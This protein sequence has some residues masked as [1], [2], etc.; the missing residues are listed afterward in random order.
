M[1]AALNQLIDGIQQMAVFGE[2]SETEA[3]AI[4]V[5][6]YI[7]FYLQQIKQ[8]FNYLPHHEIQLV[9][10][11][12]RSLPQESQI[13]PYLVLVL[14]ELVDNLNQKQQSQ[15]YLEKITMSLS[16]LP[17]EAFKLIHANK[18]NSP[19]LDHLLELRQFSEKISHFKTY[20]LDAI[21]SFVD[22]HIAEL[23]FKKPTWK[24]PQYLLRYGRKITE[25]ISNFFLWHS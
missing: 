12:I 8:Q 4:I 25:A 24:N 1:F 14:I 5:V 21:Y 9:L 20:S 17:R 3:N 18:K 19:T 7:D 2:L 13:L 22:K 10:D 15:L 6:I 23:V 16:P 11:S